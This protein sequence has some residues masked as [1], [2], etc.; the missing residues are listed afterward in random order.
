MISGFGLEGFRD[1]RGLGRWGVPSF[2]CWGSQPVA[3]YLRAAQGGLGL[4]FP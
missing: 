4:G 3:C 2:G 1:F